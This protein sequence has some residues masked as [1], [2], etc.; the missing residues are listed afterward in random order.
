MKI[1]IYFVFVALSFSSCFSRTLS[2]SREEP[3]KEV[4]QVSNRKEVIELGQEY[5][6]YK[7]LRPGAQ[8]QHSRNVYKNRTSK[9]EDL[10]RKVILYIPNRI[11]DLIDVIR[12]DLGIGSAIGYVFRVTK[13]GQFG[14]RK[15][16]PASFRVGF[17]GRKWPFL[18]EKVSEYGI[19]PSFRTSRERKVTDFELGMGAEL[20]VLGAYAGLSFDELFDFFGGL[21]GYDYKL[22]D[23]K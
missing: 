11:L 16:K 12:L 14:Y 6:E 19:G 21:V 3:Q 13:Y 23:I 22:D 10:T 15:M 7:K 17:L 9:S 5:R 18:Y 1:L 8:N 20:F 2:L 4:P